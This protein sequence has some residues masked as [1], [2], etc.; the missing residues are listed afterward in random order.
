MK[1]NIFYPLLLM[2][3]SML[4][5]TSCEKEEETARALSGAWEGDLSITRTYKGNTIKPYKTVVVFEQEK[6]TSLV[7]YGY[8]IEYYDNELKEVYNHIQWDVWR[9]NNGNSGVEFYTTDWPEL[10]FIIYDDYEM[11]DR[12]FSGVYMKDDK[13]VSFTLNRISTAPDV[14]KVL[15]WGYNELLP[16]WNVMTYQGEMDITRTYNGKS[17]KPTSVTITFDVDPGYNET[18]LGTVK[19]YIREDYTD[20]PWGAYLADE[21]KSWRAYDFIGKSLDIHTLDG[22]EYSIY[23]LQASEQELKGEI[24]VETNVFTPFTLKRVTT[25]KWSAITNWGITSKLK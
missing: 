1:R 7:G 19:S 16:T 3:V 12:T 13:E 21:I 8:M 18:N 11:N 10:K 22:T 4:A 15:Y 6:A 9:R 5:F 25:P 14:S 23:N 20:A 17:Y 24:F 2:V